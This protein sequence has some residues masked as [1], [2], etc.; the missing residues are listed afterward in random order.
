MHLTPADYVVWSAGTL[1]KVLFCTLLVRH[2][3]FRQLPCFSI[4]IFVSVARTFV[5]LWMYRDPT[6]E[7]GIVFNSYWVPQLILLVI[8]GLVVAE[9][10]W[11]TVSKHRG[12]W[13][14]AWRLLASVAVVLAAVAVLDV[15]QETFWLA[16]VVLRGERGLEMA[17]L[18]MVVALFGISRY[19]RIPMSPAAKYIVLGLAVHAALQTINSSLAF[20]FA[21]QW[22]SSYEVWWRVIRLTSFDLALALWCWGL[23][24]PASLAIAAPQMLPDDLYAQV[25][26]QVNF[27]LTQLNERLLEMLK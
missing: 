19:Y 7:A 22:S 10:A 24:K 27:R 5:L 6:L 26:P 8:K 13:A 16:P 2:E 1:L 11:L 14:L 21:D 4:F 25:T 15:M 20:Q 9:L 17:I 3:H 23:R 12:I 18:S